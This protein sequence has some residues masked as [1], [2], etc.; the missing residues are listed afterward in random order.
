MAKT[1]LHVHV[2]A[3]WGWGVAYILRGDLT[4]GLLRLLM[5]LGGLIHGGACFRNLTVLTLIQYK[6]VILLYLVRDSLIYGTSRVRR[7]S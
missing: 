6:N 4:E 2:N 5:S 7:L 1:V 3:L